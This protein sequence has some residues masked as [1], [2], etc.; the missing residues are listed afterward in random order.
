MATNA[1]IVAGSLQVCIY[2]C[3]YTQILCP[4][5]NICCRSFHL[6]LHYVTFS[7]HCCIDKAQQV[8]GCHANSSAGFHFAGDADV[9]T[10]WHLFPVGAPAEEFYSS[11]AGADQAC[12]ISAPQQDSMEKDTQAQTALVEQML[13]EAQSVMAAA[14]ISGSD[15][16]QIGHVLRMYPSMQ[17]AACIWAAAFQQTSQLLQAGA[18]L[19]HG[20]EVPKLLRQGLLVLRMM[21]VARHSLSIGSPSMGKAIQVDEQELQ[22]LLRQLPQDI[23][24][25]QTQKFIDVSVPL[26]KQDLSSIHRKVFCSSSIDANLMLHTKS[27][28]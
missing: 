16:L 5:S 9:A 13:T 7:L 4:C 14:D 21:E 26:G 28:A 27:L 11:D 19:R 3:V 8:L 12:T 22:E 1:G 10:E 23:F 20:A 25:A 24:S 6:G 2:V 18:V 17:R 15:E